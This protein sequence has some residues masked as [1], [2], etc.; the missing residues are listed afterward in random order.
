[1]QIPISFELEY[2]GRDADDQVID[3][4]DVS[5]A[6]LGF[7]RSL[8]LT[9]HL[10]LNREIITQ[11]PAL[12][13]A[14][15]LCSPPEDG[16]WKIKAMVVLTS[17]YALTTTPK[18]TMLGNVVLSVY[19]YVVSESLGVHVDYNKSIG[20]LYEENELK[21]SDLQK[22][23]EH[24]VD[25]LI[26]KCSTAITEM[27]RPIS[28]NE[29]AEVAQIRSIVG[30]REMTVAVPLSIETYHYIHEA[31]EADAPEVIE[32]R[33][34]S[35][36]SNTFKGRI[37]VF[38]EGRPVAFELSNACR[39][40]SSV[41]LVVASLSVNAVREYNNEWSTVYCKV[42]RVTTRSGH[43][44]RYIILEISHEPIPES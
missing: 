5:Q 39:T 35:Y 8:A 2:R 21:Q 32:G 44:K 7:Q 11:A 12:R 36:N 14:R 22:I 31:F 25:S 17:A 20:Q 42:I 1:M 3:F 40:D 18:D 15:I 24:H 19:D 30:G 41:Q 16:S 37:F 38:E 9:T 10:V 28:K 26:E 6:L 34:S 23:E 33:V 27:H 4:Y 43:L 13:G 29:T